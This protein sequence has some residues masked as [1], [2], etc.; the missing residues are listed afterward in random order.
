MYV[1]MQACMHTSG[2]FVHVPFLSARH[3]VRTIVRMHMSSAGIGPLL[4]KR[5]SRS[6]EGPQGLSDS[7]DSGHSG[8]SVDSATP[9]T[10]WTQRLR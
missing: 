1:Y 7:G 2:M 6:F 8:D 3:R 4:E 5:G 10:P 9:V